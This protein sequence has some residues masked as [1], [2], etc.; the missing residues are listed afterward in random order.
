[1]DATEE[2][3]VTGAAGLVGRNLV[4]LPREAGYRRIVAIDKQQEN[5]D[6]LARD[7]VQRVL[8]RNEV[9][10]PDRAEQRLVVGVSSS[11]RRL[12]LRRSRPP[13]S[14]IQQAASI[15]ISTAC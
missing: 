1:V 5:L 14:P 7:V 10:E 9:F 6:L 12:V 8:G 3:I 2:I 4:L 11:H 13:Y 15:C